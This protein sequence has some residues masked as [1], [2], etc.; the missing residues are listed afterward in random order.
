MHSTNTLTSLLA[1]A[2][3]RWQNGDTD[4]KLETHTLNPKRGLQLLGACCFAD[5][6]CNYDAVIDSLV[7]SAIAGMTR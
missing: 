3:N 7:Q 5:I 6:W 4:G 1:H 2:P